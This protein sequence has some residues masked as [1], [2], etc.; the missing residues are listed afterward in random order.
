MMAKV[1]WG[2]RVAGLLRRSDPETPIDVMPG[3]FPV[4]R[5]AFPGK[6]GD[7]PAPLAETPLQERPPGVHDVF[8]GCDLALKGPK[9]PDQGLRTRIPWVLDSE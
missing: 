1:K 3:A 2:Q 5:R 7:T 8:G 4:R 9:Y 6:A